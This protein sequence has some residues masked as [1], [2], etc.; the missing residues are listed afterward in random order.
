MLMKLCDICHSANGSNFEIG[1]CYICEGGA[2][3]TKAMIEKAEKLIEN[4]KSFSISTL[5]PKDWFVR[6]ERIWD[7]S[8]KNTESIKNKLNRMI[9][10]QLSKRYDIDGDVRLI[11][12][13]KEKKVTLERNAL[14]IF[15]RYRKNVPGLSQSRWTCQNC[16]GKGC[17]KCNGKGK[18]YESVEE[19][20]GEPL[21]K[22]TQADDY[23][24]HASGREDVD[25]T[26]SAGRIFVMMLKNPRVREFDLSIDTGKEVSVSD[27]K[28]VRRNFVE[29]VTESHFD[30]TYTVEVEFN[31]NISKEEVQLI[32]SL[33]G[34]LIR[35]KTPK[36]VVHRRA[37]I[38][39]HRKIKSIEVESIQG[40]KAILKIRAEAGTYIK[41]LISGDE[42]RTEPNISEITNNSAKC[43]AL[44]VSEIDDHY[45]DQFLIS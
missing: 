35:Q 43:I 11:F 44:D 12:D 45:I 33:E 15:G 14:F 9:A 31:N 29:L 34:K 13:Y 8:M 2:L 37:D 26:N 41:E 20:I 16:N 4:T 28:I 7:I 1:E 40:K 39:R 42:G 22:A 6:E 27:L 36:R 23:V 24:L 32:Q 19:K 21:K 25:A 3:E 10:S 5:I 17:K 30:K 18:Y 38:L